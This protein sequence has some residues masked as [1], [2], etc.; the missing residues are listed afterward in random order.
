MAQHQQVA[1]GS[2]EISATSAASHGGFGDRQGATT[3]SQRRELDNQSGMLRSASTA[4]SP[5]PRRVGRGAR[6]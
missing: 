1:A 3:C 5:G 6:A 4:S 2:S